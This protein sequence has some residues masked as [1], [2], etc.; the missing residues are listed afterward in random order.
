M[1]KYDSAHFALYLVSVRDGQISETVVDKD[2]GILTLAPAGMFSPHVGYC[3]KPTQF[4]AANF[5]FEKLILSDETLI[6][7]DKTH[8]SWC[9]SIYLDTW[10]GF[11]DAF[12][13]T[14]NF[15]R[16][17][18]E[19][20]LGGTFQ[21][22]NELLYQMF[23][24]IGSGISDYV[25]AFLGSLN[26]GAVQG[27]DNI[28]SVVLGSVLSERTF[29]EVRWLWMILPVLL[30]VLGVVFLVVVRSYTEKLKLPLWKT[31]TLAMIYHGLDEDLIEGE[32][33]TSYETS[34]GMAQ[35]A[36]GLYVRLSSAQEAGGRS[37]LR[38]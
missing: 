23:N 3:W 18:A 28:T 32:A 11:F 29:V 13:G 38:V 7:V 4:G 22:E 30:N 26:F 8:R 24:H 36:R 17:S 19:E 34:S 12:N 25:P 9:T 33:G 15:Q 27:D 35:A 21:A 1:G 16:P 6:L 20:G 31:S 37:H 10:T 5:T 2:D 14:L